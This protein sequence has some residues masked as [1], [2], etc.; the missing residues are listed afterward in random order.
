MGSQSQAQSEEYGKHLE[1]AV[2]LLQRQDLL[3]AQILDQGETVSALSARALKEGAHRNPRQV[4]TSVRQLQSQYSA[5][6]ALS[7]KR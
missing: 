5:L 4:Q 6:Q 1:E 2:D 7:K 3:D